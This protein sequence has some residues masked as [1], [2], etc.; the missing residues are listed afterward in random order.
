MLGPSIDLLH[1]GEVE[2]ENRE[3]VAV[4][5]SEFDKTVLLK[6]TNNIITCQFSVDLQCVFK[7]ISQKCRENSNDKGVKLLTID[8]IIIKAVAQVNS[9]PEG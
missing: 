8:H 1:K 6:D 5:V 9:K 3:S 4:N 2:I 7:F